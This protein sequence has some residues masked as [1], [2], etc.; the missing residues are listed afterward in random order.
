VEPAVVKWLDIRTEARKIVWI[1]MFHRCVPD[2]REPYTTLD[3][4]IQTVMHDTL[5]EVAFVGGTTLNLEPEEFCLNY[6]WTYGV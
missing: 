3:R 1:N 2:W 5:I 4:E 6:P